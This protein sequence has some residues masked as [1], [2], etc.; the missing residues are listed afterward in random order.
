[1]K[2]LYYITTLFIVGFE[3]VLPALSPNSEM[4]R[5]AMAHFGYPMYFSFML[6]IFKTLGALAIIIPKVPSRV[7]EWAY[8][9]FGLSAFGGFVSIA[10]VDGPSISLI[11]PIIG[12]A[13][14]TTSYITAHKLHKI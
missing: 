7:K 2:Y 6:T 12:L 4:T 13:I 14:I 10:V 9:G 1:M 11:F 5:E 8:F 3:G